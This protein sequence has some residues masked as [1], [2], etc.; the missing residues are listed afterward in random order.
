MKNLFNKKNRAKT[1]TILSVVVV[2]LTIELLMNTVGISRLLKNLLIPTCCYIIAALSLNITVGIS[3]ELSLGHAGFMLIGAFSGAVISTAVGMHINSE[4]LR[5]ILAILVGGLFAGL[6]GFIISIPV[7]KLKGDYLAIV[8]LAF[9]QIVSSLFNNIY[10]GYDTDGFHFNFI[11]SDLNMSDKGIVII[12]GPMGTINIQRIATFTSCVVLLIIILFIIF[13]L[14]N[15]RHGRSIMAARDNRIAA[16]SVGTHILKTKTLAFVLSAVICGM[17][18]GL[19]GV[20]FS[21]IQ[22]SKFG[23]DSSILILVYV[24]LGGLGN[25]PG[26]IVSTCALYVLP[27][28]LRS[29]QNYRM[30]IYAIVLILI[31]LVSNNPTINTFKEKIINKFKKGKKNV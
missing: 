1:L 14:I 12:S 9:G 26:T 31:M 13:N 7:L 3:G 27:E 6:F 21:S 22:P 23:I 25:I 28:L 11:N 29:L 17:A 2:Y 4:V 5:I 10:L 19:Y 30:L 18:G 24:V 16:E 8:T 15:S 20:N